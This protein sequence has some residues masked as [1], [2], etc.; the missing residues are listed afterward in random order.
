MKYFEDYQVGD[1]IITRERTIT[2][3]D[4][5]FFASL[6]GD[7]YPLHTSTEYARKTQF[8]ERI[9]HG[10]LVLSIAS[11]LVSPE[12]LSDMAFIAFYGMEHVRFTA[13]TRIGDTLHVELEVIEKQD[14]ND[15][16]GVVSWRERVVNQHKE[17]AAVC[18]MSF[19]LA[20]SS[21]GGG[22]HHAE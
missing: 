3:A 5:V 10:M 13:P 8:G 18:T 22:S 14:K 17:D 16:T 12:H 9:A 6:T 11:G 1:R 15:H 4:I 20:K 7:W 2:E 21:A 19:L